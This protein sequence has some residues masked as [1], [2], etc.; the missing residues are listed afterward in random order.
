[1]DLVLRGGRV[2][3]PRSQLDRTADVL[4]L[5]GRIARVEPGIAGGVGK[6][7]RV[8][9][10]RGKYVVPGVIDLHV[11]LREPG[12]EYKEDIDS[13]TRAA[14]A[15]GFTTVCCM[16]NT[17][18]PNDCRAVTDFILARAREVARARVR[19][20]GAI[21]KGLAGETLAEIGDLRDAG[22]VALSDDGRPVMNGELMRRALEYART[23]DLPV[24]Q[25]AE[26]LHL[27]AGGVM[28]EGTAATRAGLAGQPPAAESAMVARDLEL[29]AW[30]GARY[31][32]AHVS[33]AD[34]VRLIRDAK[35]RGLPVTC[36]VTPHH[37]TLTDEACVT[38]DTATKCA[39]PLRTQGD[40]DVLLEAL[41]EGVIDCV[42]TDHAPH[43]TLEKDVE[44]DLAA[45]GMIGLE[46][47]V[48]LLLRRVA[49]G[50]L[51]L[52]R[53]IDA[54]TAAPGRTLARLGDGAGT[55]ATG[56]PADVT[57]I[58]PDRSVVAGGEAGCSKSRNSPFRGWDLRG[59]ASLTLMD[60]RV[61]YG[62]LG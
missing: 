9:D 54:L 50:R 48:P 3:D 59:A 34:T 44:F 2:I 30:T 1:M 40:V 38:Y 29:V 37:L 14:A 18:P 52:M 60:G 41:A 61:T 17:T 10:V 16:P 23:F 24:I 53:A 56:A 27:S 21:T 19:P 11:H 6:G 58:D 7:T 26:D 12:H 8:V 4:L 15:G 47:A 43:S 46:T 13:G 28:N 22:V 31:H 42:A 32:V 33:T 62:E 55:L 49:E 51:P 20:V 45:F 35:R 39:P 25:H 36:E 5:E 57:V